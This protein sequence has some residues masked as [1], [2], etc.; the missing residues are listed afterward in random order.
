MKLTR[1]LLFSVYFI[2]V[3]S[4]ANGQDDTRAT[5]TWQVQKYDIAA[6]LPTID[7]DRN[8]SVKA[9]VTVKNISSAPASTLSLRISPNADIASISI[10]GTPAEFTKRE[11]KLGATSSL[12]R[13]SIRIPAV[14]SNGTATVSVDYKLTIKD[15]S[16]LSSMSPAGS[17]FLPLSF[18][19]PTPNSWYFARGADYAPI[20]IKINSPAGQS[21]ISS[22]TENQGSYNQ[23]IGG[24]P[25]FVSGNWE[26]INSSGVTVFLPKDAMP[27]AR[28]RGRHVA[29]R[30]PWR[31]RREWREAHR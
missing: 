31:A 15:N 7:T 30:A 22:G 24:Q 10:N 11:E 29:R 13:L 9:V 26:T 19:Y 3:V 17:T 4:T 12:Q 28:T 1:F 2:A 6:T 27:E 23:D 14:A 8:L 16:G 20:Q 25:F 18:W 5:A 21:V